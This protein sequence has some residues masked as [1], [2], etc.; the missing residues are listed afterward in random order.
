MARFRR[1]LAWRVIAYL[2]AVALSL[3]LCA[4]G[5]AA[6]GE[7]INRSPN[8]KDQ[9]AYLSL[10]QRT[11][12][13]RSIEVDGARPPLY[14]AI[15]ALVYHPDL[16]RG[17]Y[18][19][20]CKRLNIQVT[21]G[22]WAL[23]L[24]PLYRRLRP[25]SALA[26]WC[27]LGFTVFMFYAPYV[28]AEGIFYSLAAWSFLC[29]L[30]V[31]TRPRIG[32]ALVAGVATGLAQLTK[33]SM[34]PSLALF[35][36]VQSLAALAAIGSK[37]L[38]TESSAALR[39]ALRRAVTIPVVLAAFLL[40]VYPHVR[41]NKQVF[42][43]YFYNVNSKFYI[44]YDSWGQVERGTRKY[45]DRRGFPDMPPEKLPSAERYLATHTWEDIEAR[46]RRGAIGTIKNASSSHGF[47]DYTVFAALSAAVSLALS[48]YV[49]RISRQRWP[50]MLFS[51][52][53]LCGYF[54]MCT[55]FFAIHPGVRFVVMLVA[56]VLFIGAWLSDR[57]GHPAFGKLGVFAIVAGV[58]LFLDVPM[59]LVYWINSMSQAGW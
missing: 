5:A 23:L 9:S 8:P 6:H 11:A 18:F 26:V 4:E 32:V 57:S 42:G 17:E 15:L 51:A 40:V 59:A 34:L 2:G 12:Q 20:R 58:S 25:F 22:G 30:D 44:W 48:P 14:S 19:E 41:V 45:G 27:A 16:S 28:K 50:A 47:F 54:L 13:T 3:F 49:R 33:E 56:P 55:W 31:L 7:A 35:V 10:G 53:Y 43:S 39:T 21:L 1:L 24:I 37:L 29:T 38:R 46:I 52:G 36:T